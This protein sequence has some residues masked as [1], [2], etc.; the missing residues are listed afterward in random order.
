[1]KDINRARYVLKK[2]EAFGIEEDGK[3]SR[4]FVSAETSDTPVERGNG[5][6]RENQYGVSSTDFKGQN[7]PMSGFRGEGDVAIPVHEACWKIFEKVSTKILGRV[8]LDGFVGLWW[9]E[10]CGGCGFQGLN[11]DPVIKDLKQKWWLH[12]RGTEYLATNPVDIPGFKLMMQ[13]VYSETPTGDGAFVARGSV[14]LLSK[15]SVPVQRRQNEM[16]PFT[17]L[18]TELKNK[19][20][21][22]LSPKDIASLRLSSRSFRQLPKQIF[23]RF[24][25]EEIPWFW[26]IDEIRDDVEK[27]YQTA[28]KEQYGDDLDMFEGL[29]PPNWFA[30]VKERME[31]KPMDINWF[32]VYKQVKVME[33]GSLGLRNRARIWRVTEEIV[34]KIETMRES[35]E[36]VTC[37]FSVYPAEMARKE[38]SKKSQACCP[39]CAKVQIESND[40]DV[41][42]ESSSENSSGEDSEDASLEEVSSSEEDSE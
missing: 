29:M 5:R 39:R 36:K 27:Y 25:V 42:G 15:I 20:L 41:L 16:D 26:E 14:G 30:F 10:A 11:H 38:R 1:M 24:I 12:R 28:F 3:E 31:K 6:L 35:L 22:K 34:R 40:E 19:I 8:D 18:P 7:Y 13:D 17:K 2:P 4:Y 9:R 33:K 21:A 23:K 37:G 32:E